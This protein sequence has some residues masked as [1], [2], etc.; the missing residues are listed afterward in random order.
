M[1]HERPFLERIKRRALE[2][3]I[4]SGGETSY[5]QG[6]R[7]ATKEFRTVERLKP[8][9]L[10]SRKPNQRS[11]DPNHDP[12]ASRNILLSKLESMAQRILKTPNP[13][14]LT[15]ESAAGAV[16]AEPLGQPTSGPKSG[17]LSRLIGSGT[18]SK[19]QEEAKNPNPEPTEPYPYDYVYT[20]RSHIGFLDDG[21][22]PIRFRDP[23]TANWRR[24]LNQ[25]PAQRSQDDNDEI[26]ATCM[27]SILAAYDAQRKR[28]QGK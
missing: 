26:D 21:Q 15:R 22:F 11:I 16:S 7:Q 4:G 1:S 8:R 3:L 23:V 14:Q 6:L 2:I 19:T 27:D 28:E 25:T 5:H 18:V 12:R 17:V 10:A 13:E 20:G 24:S 9:D